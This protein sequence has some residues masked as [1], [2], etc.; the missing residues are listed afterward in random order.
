LPPRKILN[1]FGYGSSLDPLVARSAARG[2]V[3]N[4]DGVEDALT[5]LD[6]LGLI[7]AQAGN[8]ATELHETK[9]AIQK[10][11]RKERKER[12]KQEQLEKIGATAEEIGEV[13]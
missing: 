2:V 3:I 1:E 4:S 7:P 12:R 8:E 13:E 11:S 10:A 9:M 5:L 6:M